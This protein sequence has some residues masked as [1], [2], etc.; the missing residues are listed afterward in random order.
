MKNTS[1]LFNKIIPETARAWHA[2]CAEWVRIHDLPALKEMFAV[3][4]EEEEGGTS[5]PYRSERQKR[6]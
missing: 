6:G 1:D 5:S 3:R 4:K 2:G